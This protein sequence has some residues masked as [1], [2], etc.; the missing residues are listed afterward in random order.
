[1]AARQA[2]LKWPESFLGNSTQFV[3][4][5]RLQAASQTAQLSGDAP[6]TAFKMRSRECVNFQPFPPNNEAFE[7]NSCDCSSLL[8]GV[9]PVGIQQAGPGN[10]A[11]GVCTTGPQTALPR[12]PAVVPPDPCRHR[13]C[14]LR[15]GARPVLTA[16][17]RCFVKLCAGVNRARFAARSYGQCP[18]DTFMFW[19]RHTV[20][21]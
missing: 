1:M 17:L 2:N 12:G 5:V 3:C 15:Y 14:A 21:S 9:C 16:A 18:L 6:H 19:H 4:L 11:R 13:H 8:C 10:A 7:R 20:R